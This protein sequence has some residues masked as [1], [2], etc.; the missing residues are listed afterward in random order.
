VGILVLSW[1]WK[2]VADWNA[3]SSRDTAQRIEKEAAIRAIRRARARQLDRTPGY[4]N[5][6]SVM[7]ITA[8]PEFKNCRGPNC[9]FKAP[10]CTPYGYCAVCCRKHHSFQITGYL[11]AH[12]P[13]AFEPTSYGFKVVERGG[14]VITKEAATIIP[15]KE[16]VQTPPECGSLDVVNGIEFPLEDSVN[17]YHRSI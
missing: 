16:E 13:P 1:L 7:T 10:V 9:H 14:P 5:R 11:H 4:G 15:E 6:F 17:S 12:M 3:K 2:H 8:I